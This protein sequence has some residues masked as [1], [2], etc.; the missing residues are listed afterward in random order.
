MI[1][2]SWRA[3]LRVLS[4]VAFALIVHLS[5]VGAGGPF[6]EEWDYDYWEGDYGPWDY[7]NLN[8]DYGRRRFDNWDRDYG[9]RGYGSGRNGQSWCDKDWDCRFHSKE[10]V[11]CSNNN[12]AQFCSMDVFWFFL[13]VII[14]PC[15]CCGAIVATAAVVFCCVR[16]QNKKTQDALAQWQGGVGGAMARYLPYNAAYPQTAVGYGQPAPPGYSGQMRTTKSS[17]EENTMGMVDLRA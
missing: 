4:F 11:C 15:V 17:D 14:L 1:Q 8:R 6:R 16:K 5:L 2:M 7:Y 12:C 3:A 9:R 13:I 10:H